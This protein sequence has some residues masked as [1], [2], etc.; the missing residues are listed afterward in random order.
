M[1]I[2]CR[3]TATGGVSK[4]FA[5][6]ARRYLDERILK[7]RIGL[8]WLLVLIGLLLVAAQPSSRWVLLASVSAMFVLAFRLWDDLADLA[9]DRNEHPERV[10]AR[11]E[12]IGSF[13]AALWLLMAA[14][15]VLVYFFGGIGRVVALV[16]LVAVLFANYR[17]TA[18]RPGLR[19]TRA[20]LVLAKYPAFVALLAAA[21]GDRIV[22]AVALGVYLPPLI[23]EVRSTGIGVLLPAAAVL[24]I[25]FLGWQVLTT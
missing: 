19:P 15:A 20:A 23:D 25:G 18:F 17:A 3:S 16:V 5:T 7:P 13:R 2:F 1:A 21:P 24:G 10:L 4:L 14:L 9:H 22:P 8:L 6:E 11:S 12:R